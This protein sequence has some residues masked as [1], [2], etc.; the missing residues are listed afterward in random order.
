MR[1]SSI[2]LSL[3]DRQMELLTRAV[4]GLPSEE[5]RREF[6]AAVAS[7]LGSDPGD[8]AFRRAINTEL[9][10]LTSRGAMH[11]RFAQKE[12]KHDATTPT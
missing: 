4:A 12:I 2:P 5:T 6:V 9:A 7:R 11:A 10:R 8:H 1:P 3:S